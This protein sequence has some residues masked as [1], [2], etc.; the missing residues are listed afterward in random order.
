MRPA[1]E[2]IGPC[3][4]SIPVRSLSPQTQHPSRPGQ[5]ADHAHNQIG[6]CARSRRRGDPYRSADTAG[7]LDGIGRC[8]RDVDA[9]LLRGGERPR[10]SLCATRLCMEGREETRWA[11]VGGFLF[12]REMHVL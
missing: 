2:V 12:S 6:R 7:G 8:I 10:V 11:D 1:S 4:A 9:Q 3:S 5:D